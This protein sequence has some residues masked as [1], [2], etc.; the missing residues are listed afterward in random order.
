MIAGGGERLLVKGSD[1]LMRGAVSY[2]SAGG[3]GFA[4]G[5]ELPIV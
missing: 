2:E 5:G 3:E 4:G 1:N